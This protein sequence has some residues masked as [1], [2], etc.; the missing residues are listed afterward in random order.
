MTAIWWV[1]VLGALG[2]CWAIWRLARYP[3]GWTYAFLEEHREERK[4]L[5]DARDAVRE[6]RGTA[7]RET[8]Q[9]RTEVKRA[10][11]AYRRGVRRAESHLEQ[12]RTPHR[13]GQIEQRGVEWWTAVGL[14]R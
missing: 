10:E 11:W 4:A 12:L 5:A 14:R 1:V 6:L 3:G 7:R 13:G 8:W 2:V 9:A